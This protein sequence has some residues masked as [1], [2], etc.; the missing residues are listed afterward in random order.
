[1]SRKPRSP[2]HD[3]QAVKKLLVRI[4]PEGLRALKI[5]AAEKDA[6]LVALAIEAFNDL[7]KKNGK[8]PVVS[9]PLQ[10]EE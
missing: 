9:N 3:P 7:L 2:T 8:R 6:T 4:N 5:L 1:M 10:A